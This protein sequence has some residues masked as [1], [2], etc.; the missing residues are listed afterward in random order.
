MKGGS[1]VIIKAPERLKG[2]KGEVVTISEPE[3]GHDDQEIVS[4]RLLEGRGT[5]KPTDVVDFEVYELH[6]TGEFNG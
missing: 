3:D 2:L 4:V 5:Y 6:D 1:I